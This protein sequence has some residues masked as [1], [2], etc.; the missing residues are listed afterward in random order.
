MSVS[1]MRYIIFTLGNKVTVLFNNYID[2][3]F[4]GEK[5]LLCE[6]R[7]KRT[8]LVAEV[9]ETFLRQWKEAVAC[10]CRER[11]EGGV[12]FYSDDFS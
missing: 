9:A 4:G 7:Q 12:S 6:C 8:S 11:G 1:F 5:H 3:L 2:L 10:L